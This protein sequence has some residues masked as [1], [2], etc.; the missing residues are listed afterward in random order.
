MSKETELLIKINHLVN[1]TIYFMKNEYK[2]STNSSK[3]LKNRKH[4]PIN[5][6]KPLL[7]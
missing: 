3:K 7:P 6:M 1:F 2:S 4:F 5:F